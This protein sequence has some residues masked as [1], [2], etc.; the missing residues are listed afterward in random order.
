MVPESG[1]DDVA[2]QERVVGDERGVRRQLEAPEL[3]EVLALD[4]L[5]DLLLTPLLLD[6]DEFLVAGSDVVT[7]LAGFELCTLLSGTLVSVSGAEDVAEGVIFAPCILTG[8]VVLCE[9][10]SG[11]P[12]Q[13]GND[14]GGE[15]GRELSKGAHWQ[16]SWSFFQGRSGR[17]RG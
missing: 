8:V 1:S 3:E 10:S 17:W 9:G 6:E 14:A 13:A 12:G 16:S 7:D 5:D 11:G 2:V 15:E 4:G